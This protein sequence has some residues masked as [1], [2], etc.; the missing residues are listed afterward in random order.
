MPTKEPRRAVNLRLSEA[1]FSALAVDADKY[2]VP[3]TT[4]A[5]CHV[6]AGIQEF[7]H[8][9]PDLTDPASD[10][11]YALK[12]AADALRRAGNVTAAEAADAA[13]QE[14]SDVVRRRIDRNAL[15]IAPGWRLD[16]YRHR[17]D[18]DTGKPVL[19]GTEPIT[20]SAEPDDA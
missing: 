15:I 16:A 20:S 4:M 18:W 9:V 6:L 11:T 13:G 5:L 10:A 17:I 3:P 14:L 12:A 1:E 19:E 7:R 8:V 2:G